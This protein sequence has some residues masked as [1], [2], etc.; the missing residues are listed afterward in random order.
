MNANTKTITKA[1]TGATV[2]PLNPEDL[3]LSA[4]L[5]PDNEIPGEE[6]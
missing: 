1:A 4:T 6:D 3:D 2:V 5:D